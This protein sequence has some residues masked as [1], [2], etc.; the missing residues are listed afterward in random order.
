MKQIDYLNQIL[1]DKGQ[2]VELDYKILKELYKQSFQTPQMIADI[3]ESDVM[4]VISSLTKMQNSALN[5]I[6]IS[7]DK[8]LTTPEGDDAIEAAAKAWVESERPELLE[9]K[10]TR[11]KREIHE[12]MEAFKDFALEYLTDKIEVK[13]TVVDRSNF[14][15]LFA[16][17]I[18]SVGAL[19][20][21]NKGEVRVVGRKPSDKVVEKLASIGMKYRQTPAQTY[22]DIECT[23]DNIVN[24]IDA[25]IETA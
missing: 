25:L 10:G 19:E 8:F 12:C 16:K 4:D 11:K 1:R 5:L 9:A 23:E 17:R 24:I 13:N 21:K 7:V 22:F 14:L 2:L 18:S 6:E 15:I 20:I 3:I